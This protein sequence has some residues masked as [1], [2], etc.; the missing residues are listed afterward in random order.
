MKCSRYYFTVSCQWSVLF[1]VMFIYSLFLF[2]S[3]FATTITRHASNLPNIQLIL[4]KFLISTSQISTFFQVINFLRKCDEVFFVFLLLSEP[5]KIRWTN[6]MYCKWC[7]CTS[8]K[9]YERWVRFIQDK[10]MCSG[11]LSAVWQNSAS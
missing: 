10:D 11:I 7:I 5:Q 1:E 6:N 2:I 4:H 8:K 9:K 3:N